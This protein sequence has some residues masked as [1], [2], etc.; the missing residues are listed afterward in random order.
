MLPGMDI[1]K[2]V[3]AEMDRKGWT[4]YQLWKAVEKHVH[5]AS[6]YGFIDGRT[7]IRSDQLSHI[8]DALGIKV[9][10]GKRAG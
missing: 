7:A 8:L 10:G 6:V 9:E 4:T 5:K 2:I 3:K 1:L